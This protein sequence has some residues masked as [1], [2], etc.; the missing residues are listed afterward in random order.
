MQNEDDEYSRHALNVCKGRDDL[1]QGKSI[2]E[3]DYSFVGYEIEWIS[4][5]F[6]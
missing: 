1:L 5:E 4:E 6:D 3:G 2:F